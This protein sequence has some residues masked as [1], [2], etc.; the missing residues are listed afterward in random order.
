MPYWLSKRLRSVYQRAASP[1][2]RSFKFIHVLI[3]YPDYRPLVRKDLTVLPAGIR[4][5]VGAHCIGTAEFVG[6]NDKVPGWD[7]R[8]FRRGEE[9]I[10][11][12]DRAPVAAFFT[13]V[14]N[15]T[16][17]LEPLHAAPPTLTDAWGRSQ[18]LEVRDGRC[19]VA[20]TSAPLFLNGCRKVEVVGV[21]SQQ[22]GPMVVAEAEKGRWSR[23]WGVSQKGNFSGGATLDI[24]SD[25]DPG[26]EGHWV[27]V[28]LDVP[29]DGRYELI[30]SGNGLSRLR[31]P[32]S[33]SPFTWSLDGGEEH[34]AD[35]ALPT[36]PAYPA[37][38][39]PPSILGEVDLTGGRHTFRLKLTAR[40]DVPDQRWALWVDAIVLR[41]K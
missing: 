12:F 7:T 34:M 3:G 39:E 35:D 10:V 1:I 14:P 32:R 16:L 2:E 18:E 29:V 26:D 19:E 23:A 38:G 4:F 30:F 13:E 40:R 6:L 22:A 36:L 41:P 28:D 31:T 21:D 15:V 25:A 11:A 8:L 24:W 27:E 9:T 33:L 37:L 17:E 20:L 5:S